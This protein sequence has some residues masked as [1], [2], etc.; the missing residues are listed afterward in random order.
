MIGAII[1]DIVGSIYEHNN[2][3]AKEFPFFGDGC[4][5][6][7]DTVCTVAVADCLINDGDFTEYLSGYALRHPSRGYSGSFRHWAKQWSPQPYGSIGNG[8]AMRVSPVAYI[9]KNEAE[10]LGLAAKSASVTH[11]HPDAVAGAQATAWAIWAAKTGNSPSAIR[12]GLTARFEYDLTQSVDEIRAWY[13]HDA[14]CKG[15]VPQAIT[16]ALEANCYED[17]IRNAISIGGDSDTIACIAGGVAEAIFGVPDWI[18]RRLDTYLSDPLLE[19][20]SQFSEYVE[21]QN[22]PTGAS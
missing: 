6:T 15:T 18:T 10:V 7:D 8:S 1:G 13:K 3:K 14:T 19:V 4:R 21:Q 20:V 11:N 22:Q 5:F 12:K 9:A 16:C 2:I 17:A